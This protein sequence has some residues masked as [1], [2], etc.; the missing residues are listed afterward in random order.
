MNSDLKETTAGIH[1]YLGADGTLA[2]DL[3]Q[4]FSSDS[5]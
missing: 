4:K 5:W 3:K 1:S 2:Q